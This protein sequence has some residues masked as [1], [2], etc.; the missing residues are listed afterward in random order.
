[1]L[2]ALSY[3]MSS[4]FFR[5]ILVGAI[6]SAIAGFYRGFKKPRYISLY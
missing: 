2:H 6:I 1:M 3:V 4:D 5:P